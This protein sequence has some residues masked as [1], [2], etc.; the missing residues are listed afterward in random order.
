MPPSAELAARGSEGPAPSCYQPQ[1]DLFTVS[2]VLTEECNL[3][4][5]YCYQ[6]TKRLRGAMDRST[7]RAVIERILT[8]ESDFGHVLI[9]FIGGEVTLHWAL[10]TELI[11]WTRSNRDRWNK[12]YSFFIDTNATLLDEERKQW[13]RER[14]SWVL[15]GT[16][17]DGIRQAHDLNRCGSFDEVVSN[18]PFLAELYPDQTVK[19][20]ISPATVPHIYAGILQIMS[21]GLEAA[22]N[23][24]MED[25]WGPPEEKAATVA[26]FKRQIEMLVAFFSEHDDLPIPSIINLPIQIIHA[27]DKDRPWCGSGRSMAAVDVDGTLLPCNR[28]SRMSFDHGLVDKP[29]TDV[30]PACTTCL[31]KPACQTCEAHNWEVN[32]NPNARTRF[33]CEFTKLQVWGT[34]QVRARRLERLAESL[35]A[36]VEAGNGSETVL[37]ELVYT[38]LQLKLIG[39]IL[40]HFDEAERLGLPL[41]E[42]ATYARAGDSFVPPDRPMWSA[43]GMFSAVPGSIADR[44]E[45]SAAAADLLRQERRRRRGASILT[46]LRAGH[47]E[48]GASAEHS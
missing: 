28:Y 15:V 21:Y 13:L 19:M 7:A 5:N 36:E 27:E 45:K 31:F 8:E 20:T 38:R 2:I 48:D 42:V 41:N 18:L 6:D 4:C 37:R 3:R 35:A 47:S 24:P 11:E 12:H 16:S 9:E 22:A 10:L 43:E 44:R 40:G 17:L 26:E 39:E 23:V 30:R 1:L 25:I 34:A 29:L 33:H 46:A 32:G 14:S